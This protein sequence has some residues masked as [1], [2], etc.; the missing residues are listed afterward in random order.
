MG[1]ANALGW[2][3]TAT[4][5]SAW[6]L[7]IIGTGLS[8]TQSGVA[9]NRISLKA[10]LGSGVGI[11]IAN[12]SINAGLHLVN[13]VDRIGHIIQAYS[14]QAAN[15]QEWQN[16]SGT[17]LTR[18]KSDGRWR[19]DGATTWEDLRFPVGGLNPIGSA[20]PPT[21]DTTDG[22]LLFSKSATNVIVCQ[23]QMS[24]Q[25][26]EGTAISPHI[27][28]SP[29]TTGG[30]NVVWRIEYQIADINGTFSGSWTAQ[31]M[32]VAAGT[33]AEKHLMSEWA[34]DI[35]MTGLHIS[36][37]LKIKVSRIGGDAA[38]TYDADARLLEFDLHY[39]QDAF[40]SDTELTK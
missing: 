33:T 38:D 28:W 21:V 30:G 12:A 18:I 2:S 9:D 25:W 1:S 6:H 4:G 7:G 37:M 31:D 17:P 24:H 13:G 39:E 3:A 29:T 26:K 36:A 40:G 10:G 35:V 23:A 20:A 11:D 19:H 14:S 16:S 8:F 22:T 34:T 15:L 32:T 5:T 27:H